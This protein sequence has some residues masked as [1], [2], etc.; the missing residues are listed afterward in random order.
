MLEPV[1]K[2]RK[3]VRI[4]LFVT[5]SCAALILGSLHF[6]FFVL[7]LGNLAVPRLARWLERILITEASCPDCQATSA[8]HGRWTCECGFKVPKP[9]HIFLF[10]ASC[11]RA[12]RFYA[13]PNC[14]SSIE[15]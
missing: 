10:C 1:R 3:L 7:L 15:V 8:L 12:M 9:R 14:D 5:L 6:G 4:F 13:C 11:N 2:R